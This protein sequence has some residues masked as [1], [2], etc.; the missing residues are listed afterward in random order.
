MKACWFEAFGSAQNVLQRGDWPTPEPGPAEV[1]VQLQTTGVNPSDVKKRAGAF[2]DLLEAGPVIPHSDGAGVISA[3][4]EGVS[5]SRVGE[6]VFVYQAQYGRQRH[7]RGVRCPRQRARTKL[8]DNA[9][10]EVWACIGILI[11]TAHR[12]V[13]ADGPVADQLIL[14]RRQA[15]SA[16]TPSSG[17]IAPARG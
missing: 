11:M 10:F 14:L 4:G 6:R 1:L 3:V 5:P 17:R 2:P 8:P 7:R 15:A 9:S 13:F 12:R 16:T